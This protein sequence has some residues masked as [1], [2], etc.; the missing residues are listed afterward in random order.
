MGTIQPEKPVMGEARQMATFADTVRFGG[1][2]RFDPM[3]EEKRGWIAGE[4]LERDEEM[5]EVVI[6]ALAEVSQ[7]IWEGQLNPFKKQTGEILPKNL[8]R[9]FSGFLVKKDAIMFKVDSMKVKPALH[10]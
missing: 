4:D 1:G 9:N 10:F 7:Q 6:E 8:E 3:M 2:M 5:T